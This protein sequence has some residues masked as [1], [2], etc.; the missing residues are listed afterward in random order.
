MRV[1]TAKRI[2]EAKA[3]WP[4]SSTALDEWYRKIKVICP[5]DFSALRSFFPAADKVGPLHVF[6]IGGNKLRLIALVRYQTQ[7]L[8]IRHVLDHRDYDKGKW[9]E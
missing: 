4:H 1:I 9:K 3:K 2:W 6:N 7:R 8:Y 5:E